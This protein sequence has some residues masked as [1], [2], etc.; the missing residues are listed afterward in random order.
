M[1]NSEWMDQELE[2]LAYRLMLLTID[3][4]YQVKVLLVETVPNISCES[5]PNSV[6]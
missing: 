5:S 4:K 2:L 6:F 1:N 3:H